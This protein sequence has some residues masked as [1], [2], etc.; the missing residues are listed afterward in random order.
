MSSLELTTATVTVPEA[1]SSTDV[2]EVGCSPT[3]A[4][5]NAPITDSNKRLS[6]CKFGTDANKL[7]STKLNDQNFMQKIGI[8]PV[9]ILEL[10]RSMI[11]SFLILFVPQK[12]DNHMCSMSENFTLESPLYTAGLVSNFATMALLLFLYLLEIKR[13][14]RLI[15]YLENNKN[16]AFDNDSVGI[17]L[18]QI[19]IEKRNN[20]LYLDKYY[21]RT[22]Y[23]TM[24]LFTFNATLSGVVVYNYYLD[25]QTTSTMITNLLFMVTKLLDVYNTINTDKNIFY[26][27]YLKSKI[28]FNDVD[29]HKICNVPEGD[30]ERPGDDSRKSYD[31]IDIT[32]DIE[33]III[34]DTIKK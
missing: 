3:L 14:N 7:I 23:C 24:V 31:G 6:I 19:S 34:N 27:A 18:N 17:A 30:L 8:L 26:S 32:N 20:I 15:T 10:Y 12:C 1:T 28:Q 25:N 2:L 4:L 11:S 16:K 21:Q 22:G 29:P 5:Q 13:E 9:V 33:E